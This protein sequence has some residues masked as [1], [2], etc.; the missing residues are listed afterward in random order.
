MGKKYFSKFMDESVN[1]VTVY[2]KSEKV[3]LINQLA[4]EADSYFPLVVVTFAITIEILNEKEIVEVEDVN[5]VKKSL[6]DKHGIIYLCKAQKDGKLSPYSAEELLDLKK[7]IGDDVCLFIRLGEPE[8]KISDYKEVMSDSLNICRIDFNE[9]KPILNNMDMEKESK[10]YLNHMEYIFNVFKN[11]TDLKWSSFNR[12]SSKLKKICFIDNV[13]NLFD[14]NMVL[15][16]ARSIADR[17]KVNVLY[18]DIYTYQL[19]EI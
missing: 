13:K 17:G 16:M 18:G 19:K 2:G 5:T 1:R 6:A 10:K 11:G 15:P 7:T 12:N 9:I 8:N 14:E 3:E 4:A